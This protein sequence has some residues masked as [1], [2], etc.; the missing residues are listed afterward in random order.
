M[1]RVTYDPVVITFEN[2]LDIFF[3]IHDPTALNLQGADSGTQYRSAVFFESPEQQRAVQ[4]TIGDLVAEH[5]WG[6]LRRPSG[7]RVRRSPASSVSHLPARTPYRTSLPVVKSRILAKA[8][9][10]AASSI[11]CTFTTAPLQ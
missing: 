6:G 1:W 4:K 11:P 3:T 7:G 8:K 5:V 10:T 9:G 2:L